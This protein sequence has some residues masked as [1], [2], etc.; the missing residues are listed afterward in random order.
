MV[1]A[2]AWLSFLGWRKSGFLPRV[3]FLELLRTLIVTMVALTFNRPE[4]LTTFQPSQRPTLL[5]L[6]DT[7]KSME[8]Q[9][10]VVGNATQ[11][12]AEF[13]QPLL[14]DDIWARARET[15]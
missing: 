14:E 2:T 8:T 11:T 15:L 3:G 1:A 13:V 9:D 7:S 12:R 6:A 5:V 10:I 4:W